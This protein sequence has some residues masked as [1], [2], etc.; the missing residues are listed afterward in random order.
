MRPK[1]CIV[2]AGN[3][4]T[5]L[6]V[7]LTKTGDVIQV[8]SR[9]TDT[10]QQLSKK[11]GNTCAYTASLS[12]LTPDADFYL[13]AVNDDKIADVVAETAHCRTGIWAHTSGSIGI[14]VFDGKKEQYGVFYPLQ[15]FSRDIDVNVAKVPFF[16]EGNS[17][18][19]ADTLYQWAG[20][21]SNVVEFADSQRRK[22]LH[23]AAVFACNFANLMWL[24]A[25]E[26]LRQSRLTINYLMPLL[27]VTL[28]KLQSLSPA[29]A[30]TGPARRG[31]S[32]VINNHLTMLSG[33]K[34]EIYNLLSNVILQRYHNIQQHSK[35]NE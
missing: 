24:E 13:I 27:E 1:I 22:Q 23:V 19:V 9:H 10:A 12:K 6:A 7:A 4:A 30:M 33:E 8:V 32:D 20:N 16:I 11:I 18:H 3:V 21:I 14:D 15:T 17:A 34:H 35:H 31:D 28:A 29:Q 26:L 25:D 5:H 2:G